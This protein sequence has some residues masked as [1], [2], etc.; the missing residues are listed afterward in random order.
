[1]LTLIQSNQMEVLSEQLAKLLAIRLDNVSLLACEHVLVQSPGMSTWLRLEIAKHNGIAAALSFPLPS[2]FTWQLCHDLL[3]DVPKDNAFTKAAMTWKLMDLLPSLL[4]KPDF[5]PLK[6]YLSPQVDSTSDITDTDIDANTGTDIHTA[7]TH[8]I[9]QLNQSHDAIKLFQ[10]CGRIADIFDQYLVYRPEWILAWE[11]NQP[12]S[13]LDNR[14]TLDENQ[15]WQPILWR[16]LIDYNQHHLHASHY[17]RANLHADLIATLANPDTDLS[18]LPARLYVFGISSMPPQTLDVLYHLASRIDVIMLSLSP[19][20]HYWGDI[21]EPKTRARMALQYANKKQLDQDWEDKLEVGN[22]ILANNGQMGREL[23]DLLLSLP[24]EHTDFGYDCYVEPEP[25]NLLHGV[26]YDILQMETLGQPLGPNASLYQDIHARRTLLPSDDSITLRSCHSALR[27]VETLHDHLL[28]LLSNNSDLSPKDIVIMMPDVAAYAPYIDAVFGTANSQ[29]FADKNP[30]KGDYYIPYAIADRGAAQ[31]SPLINS[32]LSL[33]N[34][35]QSRFGLTDMIGILEVPAILRRFQ[36]DDDELSL[37]RRWLDDANVRWGRSEHTRSQL[38]VQPFTQNSWA[39]GIK[40]LI[41]GY[42]FYDDADIYRDT[43]MVQGIEGQSSQALGKLLNFLETIDTYFNLFANDYST[44]ERL[45]QLQQLLTDCYDTTDDER[46]QI[47]AIRDALVTLDTEL[48]SAGH[49]GQVDIEVLKQW[50]NQ[51]LT[52]SRVGQRYL[53]GSVNFC[54]LMPMRSIPFKVVCLL[55]MNDG[56]YPRIQHPVGFDLMAHFGP[57]KGDRS[58]RL[59]DRYL[60]LEALLSAREQLYISYIGH[61]ERDNAERIAS[62]LVSELVEYCQLSYL[63]QSLQ[64]Q[65]EQQVDINLDDAD[66]SVLAQLIQAQP[67]QPFDAKLF[68]ETPQSADSV[69]KLQHSF[70]AQWCPPAANATINNHFFEQTLPLS[71]EQA[72]EV[73]AHTHI[74]SNGIKVVELELSALI[75]FY[76]NPAQFFFNRSLKVD[77]SLDIQADDN[78]EPFS[79]NALERYLLQSRMLNNAIEHQLDSPDLELLSKLKTSGE[80]PMAPFDDLLINQYLRDISPLI[81]RVQF[82][83]DQQTMHTLNVDLNFDLPMQDLPTRADPSQSSTVRVNLVG[84]IDDILP[85]GL[86]NY[87]PGAAHGRDFIRVYLRHLCINAMANSSTAGMGKNQFSY[88]LDIGHF[89]AFAPITAEQAQAQLLR[90]ISGFIQGQT[91]PLCFMPKTAFAYVETDGDHEEKLLKA[92]QKWD[93][94]QNQFGEGHDPHNQRLFHFPEDFSEATFGALASHLLQPMLSLYHK[95]KLAELDT[96]VSGAAV[97]IQ[98][99]LIANA[100]KPGAH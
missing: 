83:Q 18:M 66:K 85:K 35:N 48:E 19:C 97:D 39:F 1:M 71:A 49:Q 73:F 57:K 62:M 91:Q 12:L 21:I 40:R 37:I 23:L 7:N 29:Y 68:R 36:L 51:R 58:R 27:E 75:R 30:Q 70:N 53:A 69:S 10:L 4:D 74:N 60:F 20:Q 100:A 42:A 3:P 44:A 54:T 61:S 24:P 56:V 99:Q 98:A 63:P 15:Q 22:P 78:D 55:G 64:Q 72:D 2:S 47:Q 87:R 34:I 5:S 38:G 11:Q 41:L 32:F 95:D 50:F 82:L 31:E 76:R 26:Q 28:E 81:N 25:N 13:S 9:L 89:H 96:F 14:L 43:L 93:D 90:F 17:H 65:L 94:G 79:L 77:L 92:Q 8:A 59:D 16:A 88:L 45:E 86:V 33:L 6:Q 84:R 67:L 52:E 46:E 80:L